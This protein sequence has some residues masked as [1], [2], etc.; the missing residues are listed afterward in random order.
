MEHDRTDASARDLRPHVEQYAQ[1]LLKAAFLLN[2]AAAGASAALMGAVWGQGTDQEVMS[3]LFWSLER[4]AQ[5]LLFAALSCFAAFWSMYEF[6]QEKQENDA[7]PHEWAGY[8][9]M[10]GC[11]QENRENDSLRHEW[12][13]FWHGVT[14][15]F[16][17]ASYGAFLVGVLGFIYGVEA[18]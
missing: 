12:G 10:Y 13:N 11:N 1:I 2:G 15:G 17:V 18:L 16:V 5:G 14:L 3:V 4:F 8:W 7:R 6:Y 9:S